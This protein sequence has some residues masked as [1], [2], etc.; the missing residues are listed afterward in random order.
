MDAGTIEED[1]P[2]A[3]DE[4]RPVKGLED[5][6]QTVNNGILELNPAMDGPMDIQQEVV[7]PNIH[8][9]HDVPRVA[10]TQPIESPQEDISFNSEVELYSKEAPRRLRVGVGT[11][12]RW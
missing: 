10:S 2:V 12:A 8:I 9:A 3:V 5:G 4:E 11:Y 6:D 7:G 1:A